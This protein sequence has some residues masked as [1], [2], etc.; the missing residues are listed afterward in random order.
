MLYLLYDNQFF[1]ERSNNE[2]TSAGPLY[3]FNI[4][5]SNRQRALKKVKQRKGHF[6]R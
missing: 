6:T 3:S 4:L 1:K 5:M 2:Q